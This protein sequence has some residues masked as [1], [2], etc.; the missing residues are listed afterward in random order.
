LPTPKEGYFLSDGAKVPGVTTI[1]GR[2]KESGGLMQWAFAQGR[3]GAASLYETSKVAADIGTLAHLMVEHHIHHRGAVERPAEMSESDFVRAEAA[4]HSYLT[5][6]EQTSLRV[7]TTEVRLVS[8]KHRFGGTID[9][10]GE[11]R[12]H[13]CLPDW[14]TSNATYSD[15]LIQIAAYGALWEENFPDQPLEGGFH[16]LRFAKENGDFHHHHFPRL[17]DG[18]EMFVCLRRAWDLDKQLKKRAA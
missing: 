14:K 10:L 17:D 9:A 11:I 6:E 7:L 15:Y 18:F 8:E 3:S 16:L 2:F 5:W 13:L 12:G 4:F 1:L